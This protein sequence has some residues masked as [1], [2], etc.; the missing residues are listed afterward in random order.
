MSNEEVSF[1]SKSD[2]DYS[3]VKIDYTSVKI[4]QSPEEIVLQK[5]VLVY[6]ADTIKKIDIDEPDKDYLQ[7]YSL[8]Y[9][10]GMTQKEIADEIGISQ[11]EVSKRLYQLMNKVKE[12]IE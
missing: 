4:P 5:E 8:R 3:N 6:V 2:I 10:K 7:I 12:I 11:S 9:D 1:D